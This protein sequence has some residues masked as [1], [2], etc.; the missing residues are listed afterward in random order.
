MKYLLKAQHALEFA[1][2]C[3]IGDAIYFWALGN[4]GPPAPAWFVLPGFAALYAVLWLLF[5][6]SMG[7][8]GT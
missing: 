1:I 3:A 4:G 2:A 8:A 5:E 6:R 7:R